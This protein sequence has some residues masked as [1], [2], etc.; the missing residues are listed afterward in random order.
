ML[1]AYD[2]KFMVRIEGQNTAP[3]PAFA[4]PRSIISEAT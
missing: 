4:H 2:S 3:V 1:D